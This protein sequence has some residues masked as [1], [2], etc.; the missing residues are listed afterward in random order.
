MLYHF[1][2]CFSNF[3]LTFAWQCT[4][5]ISSSHTNTHRYVGSKVSVKEFLTYATC[6]HIIFNTSQWHCDRVIKTFFLIIFQCFTFCFHCALLLSLPYD[7]MCFQ[8]FDHIV[9]LAP[10]PRLNRWTNRPCDLHTA[11][12]AGRPHTYNNVKCDLLAYLFINIS[13]ALIHTLSFLFP[14]LLLDS[15][16]QTAWKYILYK[17]ILIK[18]TKQLHWVSNLINFRSLLSKISQLQLCFLAIFLTCS[19]PYY[20]F[21][22]SS[23]DSVDICLVLET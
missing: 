11:C 2:I 16:G 17:F 19:H 22:T 15:V 13:C 21:S 1:K 10:P 8:V 3:C 9:C 23:F 14:F 5:I 6:V 20:A 4:I 7:C 12:Q 18:I